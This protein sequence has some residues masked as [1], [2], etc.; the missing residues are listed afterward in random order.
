MKIEE[1]FW[2]RE[3]SRGGSGRRSTYATIVDCVERSKSGQIRGRAKERP[4]GKEKKPYKEPSM[5][6]CG[7]INKKKEKKPV[8]VRQ[9]RFY[10]C[11]YLGCH[12]RSSLFAS[13]FQS[14]FFALFWLRN[15][16]FSSFFESL[17]CLLVTARVRAS[18]LICLFLDIYIYIY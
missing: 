7:K 10:Y 18:H 16:F 5:S 1:L 3:N 14:I 2:K 9:S 8:V 11:Q 12:F 17:L 13:L 15:F 6:F 4:M